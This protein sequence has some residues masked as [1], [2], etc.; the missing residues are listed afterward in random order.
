MRMVADDFARQ[1]IFDFRTQ[2]Y[3]GAGK[4]DGEV[5]MKDQ[6]DDQALPVCVPENGSLIASARVPIREPREK[7]DLN[8]FILWDGH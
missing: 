4:H 5:V 6:F 2:I 1:E 8:R 7:W 3:L